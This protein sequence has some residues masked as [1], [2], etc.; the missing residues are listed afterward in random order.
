MLFKR[1]TARKGEPEHIEP[2]ATTPSGYP[3]PLRSWA[4]DVAI[5]IQ[6]L[7]TAID[8]DQGKPPY[9]RIL[10]TAY[11]SIPGADATISGTPQT[12]QASSDASLTYNATTGEFTFGRTG[13]YS[14]TMFAELGTLSAELTPY[15]AHV[16]D[17]A[18]YAYGGTAKSTNWGSGVA[19]YNLPISTANE[20]W[21]GYL[22]SNMAMSVGA[23]SISIIRIGG[24]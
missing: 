2:Y 20:K 6:N 5:D 1:N 14:V 11:G 4:P 22:S 16:T 8:S 23:L 17:S 21:R 18:K 13:I 19:A 9:R 12:N 3:Y 15:F 10:F 24:I 7:A